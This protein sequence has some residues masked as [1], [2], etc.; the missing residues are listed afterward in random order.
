MGIDNPD[1]KLVVQWDLPMSFDS[2]IQRMGRASRK[3][4]QAAF[5]LFTP[6]WAEV[7]EPEDVEKSHIKR[8]DPANA[9]FQLSDSSRPENAKRSP[10]RQEV[11]A[12]ESSENGSVADSE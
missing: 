8:T 7:S 9:N 12:V 3:G 10:L 11:D 1:I 4:N 6:N 2:M 5:V